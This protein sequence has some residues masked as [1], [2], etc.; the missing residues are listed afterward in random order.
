MTGNAG[1]LEILVDGEPVPPIGPPAAVRRDVPLDA[2]RLKTARDQ[3]AS[4][5]GRFGWALSSA[6]GVR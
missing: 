1:A 5:Q 4:S 6:P 3:G 2:D